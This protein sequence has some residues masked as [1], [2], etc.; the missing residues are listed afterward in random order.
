MLEEL[1]TTDPPIR[2]NAL[3]YEPGTAADVARELQALG[4]V[5]VAVGAPLAGPRNGRPGRDC[6]ALLL[7][8]GVAPQAATAET[9]QLADLL[10]GMPSFAPDGDEPPA[11]STRA[12]TAAFR[13]S[14]PTPTA[15]SARCRPAGCRPSVTRSASGCASRSWP[16]TT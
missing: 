5:V 2:L 16:V 11:R 9:R 6:D 12:R 10:R 1:R 7:R 13:C 15:C 4:E 14:R 8:R 3:F